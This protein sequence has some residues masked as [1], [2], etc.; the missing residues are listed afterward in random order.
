LR[1]G[2]VAYQHPAL[3]DKPIRV[4][5][6][7]AAIDAA[8]A[9]TD[10]A[11][12]AADAWADS[13][14]SIPWLRGDYGTVASAAELAASA[15]DV[16]ARR[17][18]ISPE[19][20]DRLAAD[21]GSFAISMA[22]LAVPI[23]A[24]DGAEAQTRADQETIARKDVAALADA[25]LWSREQPQWAAKAWAALQ[26]ELPKAQDW[27]VW[28]D[29]YEE[30]LRGVPRGEAYDLVFATVPQAEWDKGP[31]G[32]NAWIKARLPDAR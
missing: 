3:A 19:A 31:A 10:A 30:R 9:A 8:S 13:V 26:A 17:A 11:K 16:C 23:D 7:R 24:R 28:I 12:A 5:Q 25:P 21:A 18:E 22:T 4:R 20:T 32:A 6:F 29:W 2:A 27:D 1:P 15:A 14:F